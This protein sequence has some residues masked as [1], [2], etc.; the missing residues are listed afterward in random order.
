MA[1]PEESV[2]IKTFDIQNRLKDINEP[3]SERKAILSEYVFALLRTSFVKR[4]ESMRVTL[5]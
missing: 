3:K 1:A 2:A 4:N 5:G